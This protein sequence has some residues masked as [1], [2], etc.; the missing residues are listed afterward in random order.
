VSLGG[1]YD[2]FG[3]NLGNEDGATANLDL[4]A[5][6]V[7]SRRCIVLVKTVRVSGK[8]I[9]EASALSDAFVTLM[10]ELFSVFSWSCSG[11]K[12]FLVVWSVSY[13]ES[14]VPPDSN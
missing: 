6:E 7:T 1:V 9:S 2:S 14:I 11:K 13:P 5:A 10:A 8:I 3:G 12:A 4:V